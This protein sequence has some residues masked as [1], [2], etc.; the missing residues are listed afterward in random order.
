MRGAA[1]SILWFP[2]VSPPI[3][4][5]VPERARA[6]CPAERSAPDFGL[7]RVGPD[8]GWVR[9]VV[10][11]HRSR[12]HFQRQVRIYTSADAREG[13]CGALTAGEGK[14]RAEAWA[15]GASR[16]GQG[17][18]AVLEPWLPWVSPRGRPRSVPHVCP[19]VTGTTT[20][21]STNAVEATRL[22]F[23]RTRAAG[24][25]A[26]EIPSETAPRVSGG[27]WNPF[28]SRTSAVRVLP[29]GDHS[30]EAPGR[31]HGEAEHR[32]PRPCLTIIVFSWRETAAFTSP[33]PPPRSPP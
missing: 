33:G 9:G 21:M 13:P 29:A 12:L 30:G 16:C 24:G 18:R 25:E 23:R 4:P 8:Q 27:K 15:P 11:F 10:L 20:R 32:L 2:P 26:S 28:Q 17:S 6:L 3:G 31:T 7:R 22:N 14:G 5:Q 19:T 1:L